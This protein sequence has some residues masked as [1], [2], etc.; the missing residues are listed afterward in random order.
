MRGSPWGLE[1]SSDG[2]WGPQC[3]EGGARTRAGP[4][5]PV[6]RPGWARPDPPG[7]AP[8]LSAEFVLTRDVPRLICKD[9]ALRGTFRL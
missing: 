1:K 9:G 8:I 4:Q 2:L 6:R 3:G 7:R 5:Q